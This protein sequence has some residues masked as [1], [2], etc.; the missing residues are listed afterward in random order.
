MRL[1]PISATGARSPSEIGSIGP[2][3]TLYIGSPL[4]YITASPSSV[5]CNDEKPRTGTSPR[6]TTSSPAYTAKPGSSNRSFPT[7]PA[8][9]VIVASGPPITARPSAS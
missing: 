1:P 6:Q 3:C 7:A 9:Q 8:A 2:R 4:S 5:T